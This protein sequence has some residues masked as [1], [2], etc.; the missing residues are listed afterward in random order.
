MIT[1]FTIE[2]QSSEYVLQIEPLSPFHK[3]QFNPI[4]QEKR[5]RA[6]DLQAK[7][8]SAQHTCNTQKTLKT[9]VTSMKI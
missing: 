5:G 4:K 3:K 7:N 6:D 8:I 1:T 9:Y 2:K